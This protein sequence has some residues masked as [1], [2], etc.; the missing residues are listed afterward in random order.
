MYMPVRF[1]AQQIDLPVATDRLSGTIWDGSLALEDQHALAWQ[2]DQGA[3]WG[4]LALV[5]DWTLTGQDSDITGVL[6]LRPRRAQIGPVNGALDWQ[7]IAAFMP[8]LPIRCDMQGAVDAVT[9]EITPDGRRGSGQVRTTAGQCLR[10]GATDAPTPAPAMDL[11][12][13]PYPEGI[14]AVLTA[15]AD[16]ATPLVT[17]R[18]SDADRVVLTIHRAGAALVPGMP[19]SADSELDLPLATLLP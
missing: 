6:A 5:F 11:T 12:I 8:D 15:Q 10:I 1:A 17:A 16:S 9:L 3:S 4:S 13:S 7:T 19:D 14:A 18:L 2:I